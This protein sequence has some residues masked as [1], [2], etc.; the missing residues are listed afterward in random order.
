MTVGGNPAPRAAR[1]PAWGLVFGIFL[2]AAV[3]RLALVFAG[4][5]PLAPDAPKYMTPAR[6]LAAGHGYADDLGR[7]YVAVPPVYPLFLAAVF[8]V[9][10]ESPEAA[11]I[12]QAVLVSA[13]IAA[14]AVWLGRRHG[15][16][17]GT[18]TGILLALDPLLVPVPAFIL[19]EV[20]GMV[21]VAS[22]VVCLERGLVIGRPGPLLLAGALGGAAALNTPITLLLVPWLL[23]TARVAQAPRRPGYRA[24]LI[25]CGVVVI[26]LGTW[27][28]RN[29]VGRGE[30]IMVREQGVGSLVWGMTEYHFDWI[31]SHRDPAWA[32]LERK[33]YALSEGRTGG[34]ANLVLL[35]AAWQNFLDHPL[36]VLKQVA[37]ANFWFWVEAP[38]THLEGRLRPIRWFTLGFHQLQLLAFIISIWRLQ[39][40]GRLREWGLW[41][42]T[43]MY[44][45]LFLSL[46]FPIP[47]YYIP[48]LPL[49]DTVIVAGFVLGRRPPR[50]SAL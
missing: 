4:V 21:L 13:G 23:L 11:G 39:R 47:R 7:P 12:V 3:P 48:V 8:R 10:G 43:I 42:S 50:P 44:F 14:L 19:T 36:L 18:G 41:L 27:T 6:N 33:F 49:I 40:S 46:M 15:W 35:R 9:F 26:F 22:T 38:G 5:V 32:A 30:V 24:W 34:E 37:K 45:A 20:L 2:L 28:V 17:T 1:W 25:A 29:F 31:P 16:V